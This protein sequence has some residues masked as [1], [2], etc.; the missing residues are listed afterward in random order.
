MF[1]SFATQAYAHPTR[2]LK[3]PATTAEQREDLRERID[4][5]LD[6]EQFRTLAVA[7]T[8]VENPLVRYTLHAVRD[9]LKES[10]TTINLL[11]D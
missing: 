9:L 11:P 1:G 7:V 8:E 10:S 6:S 5:L 4:Q 2:D 3:A